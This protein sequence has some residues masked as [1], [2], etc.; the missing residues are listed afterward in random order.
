MKGVVYMDRTINILGLK[1]EKDVENF[2]NRGK[3]KATKSG[4]H[5]LII[6]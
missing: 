1:T 5:N 6:S 4:I 2:F 3:M